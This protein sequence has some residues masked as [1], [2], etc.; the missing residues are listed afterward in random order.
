ML[1]NT[2]QNKKK[3]AGNNRER[4]FQI[5]IK[6]EDVLI[7]HIHLFSLEKKN[8]KN[9]MQQKLFYISSLVLFRKL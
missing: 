9:K 1:N 4:L 8:I 5:K 3:K 6:L 7:I 2:L